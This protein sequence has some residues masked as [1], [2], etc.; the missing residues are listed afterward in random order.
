MQRE[1]RGGERPHAEGGEGEGNGRTQR[2]VQG[3]GTAVH[4]GR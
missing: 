4:R 2:E 1:G 3:R